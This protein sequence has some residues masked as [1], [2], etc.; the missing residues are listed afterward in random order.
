MAREVVERAAVAEPP[1]RMTYEEWTAWDATLEGTKTEWVDGEVIVFMFTTV[2][3]AV[4]MGFLFNLL[5]QYAHLTGLGRV[6]RDQVEMRLE[7]AA[8]V[9]DILFVAAANLERLEATRLRGAADLVV[10]LISTDSFKRDREDKF[11]QYAEAGV[12]EYW[13]FDTRQGQRAAAFYQLVDG[14]YQEMS[15]DA[16]GRFWSAVLAGFWLRPE[17]LWQDPL[18]NPWPLVALIAPDATRAALAGLDP[19]ASAEPN[20]GESGSDGTTR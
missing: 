15:L 5:S 3:H 14:A 8:R 11:A 7:R 1:R 13:L 20:A 6:F 2:R 4:M 9:P 18:P 16:E 12:R 10:E 17:W 19:A